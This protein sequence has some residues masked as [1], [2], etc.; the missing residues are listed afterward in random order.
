MFD[1][2]I[3]VHMQA[4]R[5]PVPV[6]GSFSS[7][8]AKEFLIMYGDQPQRD[9]Y[10]VPWKPH[11]PLLCTLGAP[12]ARPANRP[13]FK[14]ATD[15]IVVDF[16]N[17]HPPFYEFGSNAVAGVI[18]EGAEEVYNASLSSL[19]RGDQRVLKRRFRFLRERGFRCFA[20]DESA[21]ALGLDVLDALMTKYTPKSDFR[22]TVRDALILGTAAKHGIPL[23]TEDKLLAELAGAHFSV[24]VDGAG[25]DA[26]IAFERPLTSPGGR[27]KE[28]KGYIH[29]GWQM[30]VNRRTAAS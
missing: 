14:G 17:E 16:A 9:R 30:A 7:V 29:R 26:V 15:R 8:A 20:L 18:N 21:I 28:S 12:E 23:Q 5:R 27:S 11:G 24:P 6:E 19:S 25:S 10:Y 3:L 1:T 2:Q 22:N 13:A 4:G